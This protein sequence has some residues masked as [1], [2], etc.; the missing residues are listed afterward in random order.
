MDGKARYIFPIVIT[1]VI[2]F[3]VSGVVTWTNIGFRFDF[4]PRWLSAFIVGWPVAA[5]T[6]F[7]ATPYARL[8]TQRVV[9]LIDRTA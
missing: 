5:V 1:A 8:L 9:M 2:V 6:A 3:V 7:F 4:V